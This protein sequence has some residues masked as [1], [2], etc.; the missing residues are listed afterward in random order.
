MKRIH[1]SLIA[2][3]SGAFSSIMSAF[4]S[5]ALDKIDGDIS[6]DSFTDMDLA[7]AP[8]IILGIAFWILR[9]IGV[10]L[11]ILGIYSM[12]TCNKDGDAD[13]INIAWVKVIAG[14]MFL[15]MP[16]ILNAIGI[17]S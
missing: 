13:G 11:I 14:A 3:A 10:L 17:I 9:L 16:A 4:H 7:S 1:K 15:G 8:G 12:T 6:A 5:Y 2:V